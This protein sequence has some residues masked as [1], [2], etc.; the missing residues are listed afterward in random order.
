[1]FQQCCYNV[2]NYRLE[3]S[4]DSIVTS[5]WMKYHKV[6]NNQHTYSDIDPK[7]WCCV[8]SQNCHLYH[9]LRPIDSCR[10]YL[11]IFIGYRI[12]VL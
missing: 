4:A 9:L 3:T 1:M 2:M 7:N 8:N 11:P 6:Y 5:Q 10:N 12:I